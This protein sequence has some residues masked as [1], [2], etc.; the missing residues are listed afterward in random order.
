MTIGV[1]DELAKQQ[2]KIAGVNSAFSKAPNRVIQDDELPCFINLLGDDR[3]TSHAT[4]L[5]HIDATYT[6]LFLVQR[7]VSGVPGEAS[8]AIIPWRDTIADYFLARPT[9]EGYTGLLDEVGTGLTNGGT[10]GKILWLGV[11]YLGATF[12]FRFIEQRLIESED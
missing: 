6:A 7:A 10:P 9:L 5:W 8:A 2:R 4:D 12:T 1:L 3:Y 11:V